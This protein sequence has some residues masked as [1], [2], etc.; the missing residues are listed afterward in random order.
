M[1]FDE[2]PADVLPCV[3]ADALPLPDAEALPLGVEGDVVVLAPVVVVPSALLP[4]PALLP[5]C[6]HATLSNAAA[7]ATPIVF[8]TIWIPP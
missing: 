7:T 2:L 3:V 5:L 6:A 1:H 4:L 8:S